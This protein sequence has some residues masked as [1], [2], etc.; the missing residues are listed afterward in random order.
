MKLYSTFMVGM[1]CSLQ[2]MNNTSIFLT[3]VCYLCILA[4]VK[5]YTNKKTIVVALLY[6]AFLMFLAISSHIQGDMYSSWIYSILTTGA[7]IIYVIIKT[8]KDE[9]EKIP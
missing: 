1:Y 2:L 6:W 4:L 5:N 8:D 3:V 9:E 7:P